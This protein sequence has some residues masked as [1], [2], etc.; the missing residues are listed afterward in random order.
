MHTVAAGTVSMVRWMTCYFYIFEVALGPDSCTQYM[1]QRGTEELVL[2]TSEAPDL[3]C[4][5]GRNR[6]Y[7]DCNP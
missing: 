3:S 6:F 7:L 1:E 5:V 4:G 2:R